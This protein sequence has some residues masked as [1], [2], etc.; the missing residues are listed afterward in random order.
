MATAANRAWVLFKMHLIPWVH[1]EMKGE[2]EKA[3]LSSALYSTVKWTSSP[4]WTS[5][6]FWAACRFALSGI[7]SW[8]NWESTAL[9][10]WHP[11]MKE[12]IADT[13]KNAQEGPCWQFFSFG[14]PGSHGKTTMKSKSGVQYKRF[15]FY[16]LL[17]LPKTLPNHFCY[18][19][20]RTGNMQTLQMCLEVA[21]E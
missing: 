15:S 6:C 19:G 17:S 5:L 4:I 18:C 14:N 11:H 8:A 10:K 13:W 7:Y 21:E 1:L 9:W 16:S 3:L 2:M 20:R 12:I